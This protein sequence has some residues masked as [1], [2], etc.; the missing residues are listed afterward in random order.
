MANG[1][2]DR[3]EYYLDI[4]KAVAKRGTCIRRNY[5]AIIIN[6]DKII[7]TG[8]T[9]APKGEPNCC[10]IGICEREKLK[11]PSGERYELCKSVHAE[12][13]AVIHAGVERCKGGTIFIVGLD[14]DGELIP[15]VYPCKLC[16]RVLKNAKVIDVV[17]L[18]KELN[19]LIQR[20][21][22]L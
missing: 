2:S 12:M 17:G 8:Y 6:D 5:G 13:N 22:D 14:R 11:I 1:R 15:S 16:A 18:D 4:T 19:I 9:G 10:D 3:L 21:S 7:S 20:V